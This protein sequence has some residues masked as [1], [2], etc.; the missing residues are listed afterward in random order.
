MDAPTSFGFISTAIINYR[1][2]FRDIVLLIMLNTGLVLIISVLGTISISWPIF[3]CILCHIGDFALS[4]LV[5]NP[6]NR[7]LR[8][9]FNGAAFLA[10]EKHLIGGCLWIY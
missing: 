1:D 7:P 9:R 2:V 4:D 10:A 8:T 3:V 5:I 6:L